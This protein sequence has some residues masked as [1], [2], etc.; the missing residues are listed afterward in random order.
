MPVQH[1]PPARQTRSSSTEGP[2]RQRTKFGRRSTIQEGRKR[3]KKIKFFSGVVGG[4]P[5]LSRTTFKGP[6]EDGEEEEKNTVGEAESDGTECVTSP[7]GES[8]GIGGS[9]LAQSNQPVSHKSGPS[10]LEIMQKMT[11]IM[12]NLQAASSSE[13]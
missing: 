7:M 11:A 6:G 5:G 3:A 1:S 9:N 2:L 13:E 10:L 4:F 8:Q 12:E